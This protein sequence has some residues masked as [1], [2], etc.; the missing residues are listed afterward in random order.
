MNLKNHTN[1]ELLILKELMED[2]IREN[3][4]HTRDYS[5]T[6]EYQ[7]ILID[8]LFELKIIRNIDC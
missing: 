6:K 3:Y 5:A 7:N 8:I 1:K 4:I 2:E